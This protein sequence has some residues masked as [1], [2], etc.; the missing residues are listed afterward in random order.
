MNEKSP[1]PTRTFYPVKYGEE[2]INIAKNRRNF[3]NNLYM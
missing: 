2:F 1:E 3:I